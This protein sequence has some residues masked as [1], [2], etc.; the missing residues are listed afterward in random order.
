MLNFI[1]QNI[2]LK[3]LHLCLN[4]NFD[5][6]RAPTKQGINL[7]RYVTL[8]LVFVFPCYTTPLSFIFRFF[9][10]KYIPGFQFPL[11]YEKYFSMI[12]LVNKCLLIRFMRI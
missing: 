9:V 10:G 8:V 1:V 2:K 7:P 4:M 11:L 12:R 3:L 5:L 6:N